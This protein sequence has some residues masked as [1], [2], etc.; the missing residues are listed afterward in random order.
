MALASGIPSWHPLVFGNG[1]E[2]AFFVDYFLK[3]KDAPLAVGP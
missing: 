1:F 2:I 3:E